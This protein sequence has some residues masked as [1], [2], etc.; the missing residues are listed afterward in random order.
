MTLLLLKEEPRTNSEN[1]LEQE[2]RSVLRKNDGKKGKKEEAGK[3]SQSGG[4][5]KGEDIILL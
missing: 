2:S 4:E 3:K 5:R 1:D